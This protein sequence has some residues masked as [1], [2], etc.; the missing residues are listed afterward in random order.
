VL[1]IFSELVLQINFTAEILGKFISRYIISTKEGEIRAN[2][3]N[4]V[5]MDI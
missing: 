2:I 5:D 4:V 3:E 1:N